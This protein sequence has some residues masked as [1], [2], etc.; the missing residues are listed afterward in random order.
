LTGSAV[1]RKNE[2]RQK[3]D[4]LHGLSGPG[5]FC[6]AMTLSVALDTNA[7]VRLLVNDDP[8]QADVAAALIDASSACFVLITAAVELDW[9]LRGSY[10]LPWALEIAAFTAP[11]RLRGLRP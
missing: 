3:L 10:K 11:L 4:R 2:L 9:V 1:S 5:A 7:L 6:L 8:D